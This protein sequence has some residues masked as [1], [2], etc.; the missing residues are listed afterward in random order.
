MNGQAQNTLVLFSFVSEMY[1]GLRHLFKMSSQ[2]STPPEYFKQM[3]KKGRNSISKFQGT[4][5]M[6]THLSF[7]FFPI[8][9]IIYPEIF[10][11]FH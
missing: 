6:A 9:L 5:L 11:C 10:L 7:F 3:L 8:L 1:S 4:R 2:L